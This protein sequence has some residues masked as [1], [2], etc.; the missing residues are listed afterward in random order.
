MTEISTQ[1][2]VARAIRTMDDRRPFA[3]AVAV[4]G[5]R[6]I[7]VGSLDEVTETLAG[8][9]FV[10]DSTHADHVLLPGLIDQHLHPLL[11]ATTLATEV[12]A[13]E[14]LSLIHI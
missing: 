7:A 10:I 1:V 9:P 6:I 2:H 12:I 8:E 14:D 3:T 11:G 5:S 4:R 13:T